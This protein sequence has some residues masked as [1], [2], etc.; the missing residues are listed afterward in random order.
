MKTLI[1]E[2]NN[3][4]IIFNQKISSKWAIESIKKSKNFY[5]NYQID[6]VIGSDLILEI[7]KWKDFDKVI[8]AV[9]FFIIERKEYPIESST[10]EFL[11]TNK[12]QFK[13]SSLNIPN[14]SSS[15]VRLNKNY[16]YLPTS[17]I[18]IVEKNNLYS[19]T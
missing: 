9:N 6:F 11:K 14:V 13:I 19:S 16:S 10:L 17:L 3:P 1:K 7:F 8:K 4:K 12:V 15:M 18:E 2:I 5:N